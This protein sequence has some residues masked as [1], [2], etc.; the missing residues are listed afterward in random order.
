MLFS[1]ISDPNSLDRNLGMELVRVTEA[2]ALA[3]GLW[4]GRGDK[5]GVDGAAVRAM[6]DTLDTVNLSGTV[7]I[8]EGEKDKA[9]MLV[10]SWLFLQ[11]EACT[12]PAPS[13]T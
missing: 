5:N 2:A 12:T 1:F 7:I 11:R 6:R 4:A 8:G 3:G 10:L 9:P 13:T